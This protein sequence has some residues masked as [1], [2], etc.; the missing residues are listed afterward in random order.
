MSP[1]PPI[2]KRLAKRQYREAGP[3]MGVYAIRNRA[4]GR[5]V[6][7]AS[8]NLEGSMQRDRFELHLKRHRDPV[9]L[10]EWLRDGPESFD[11]EV[12]DRLKRRDEPGFDPRA[13][14]AAL[15]TMWT[16]ELA[17]SASPAP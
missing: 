9:L 15:L 7:R 12:V 4:S 8:L 14:L 11:F 1:L 5:V 3:A 16:E 13:E 2:D 6:V 17:G 10:A